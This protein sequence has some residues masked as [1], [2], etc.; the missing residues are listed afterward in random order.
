MVKAQKLLL[1]E[2]EEELVRIVQTYFRDEGYEVRIAFNGNE[3][4][5]V[6]RDFKPDVIVSDVKM[7]QMDG[8]EFFEALQKLPEFSKIPV[9]FLTIMDD[10]SSTERA[11]QLGAAG[12][13]TKPF[14]VEEL[15]EKVKEI[16]AAGP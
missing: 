13:M 15:H 14:D 4:L 10:R 2:D 11:T 1:V 9:L 7:G 3:G 5:K 8:F 6:V 16:L 12:Y